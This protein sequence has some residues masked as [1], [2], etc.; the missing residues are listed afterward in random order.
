MFCSARYQGSK[1]AQHLTACNLPVSV[2]KLFTDIGV[3]V[4][5]RTLWKDLVK[6]WYHPVYN[7][8]EAKARN[9]LWVDGIP[10]Q[11]RVDGWAT[12]FKFLTW[13][14]TSLDVA[15]HTDVDVCFK[16]NP[17]P[18]VIRTAQTGQPLLT[19]WEAREYPAIHS[20][21]MVV[22]PSFT[23][24]Q[25]IVQK[26]TTGDYIPHTNGEQD[27]LEWY[28]DPVGSTAPPVSSQILHAGRCIK[29]KP[30][31]NCSRD[32][33]LR[34]YSSKTLTCQALL[35]TCRPLMR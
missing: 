23:T 2:H 6:S 3:T 19:D 17:D 10:V 14:D 29:E 11:H 5:D 12:Y 33:L 20:E 8:A 32:A 7:A 28:F 22:R 24:F 35:E 25:R 31:G 26:A 21:M 1:L 34:D 9:R 30:S 16:T 4:H 18:V 15:L 27:V 13:N